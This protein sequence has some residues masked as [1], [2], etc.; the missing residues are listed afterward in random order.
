MGQIVA[1]YRSRCNSSRHLFSNMRRT[2]KHRESSRPVECNRSRKGMQRFKAMLL[3]IM[4]RIR[5]QRHRTARKL[6][7][8]REFLEFQVNLEQ[9]LHPTLLLMQRYQVVQ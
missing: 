2:I 3:G 8:I 6:A 5:K 1:K 7:V 9:Q 4:E